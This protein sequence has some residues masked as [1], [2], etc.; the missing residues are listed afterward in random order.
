MLFSL[1]K[2]WVKENTPGQVTRKKNAAQ[3]EIYNSNASAVPLSGA[4]RSICIALMFYFI[5]KS[6]EKLIQITIIV[7]V[8]TLLKTN[9]EIN[10]EKHILIISDP[11]LSY[12]FIYVKNGFLWKNGFEKSMIF[13]TH[14]INK[15]S[16]I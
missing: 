1:K 7:K 16:K 3:V 2:S 5:Q 15:Y 13:I 14:S 9:M 6:V 8:E 4:E 12:N 11:I 10:F